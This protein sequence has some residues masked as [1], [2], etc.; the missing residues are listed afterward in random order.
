MSVIDLLY[1]NNNVN[2]L[3]ETIKQFPFITLAGATEVFNSVIK[4]ISSGY[5]EAIHPEL[6]NLY[7]KNYHKA[8][9]GVLGNPQ[10]SSKYFEIAQKFN[11]NMA[12]F[13]AYKSHYATSLLQRLFKDDVKKFKKYSGTILKT[14]NR[15]QATEYNTTVARTRSAKQFIEF[16]A[17]K[18]LY[19]NIEWLATRS[20]TPRELHASFVGLVLPIEHEFWNKNQP[21]NLYNCKCDWQTTD[22]KI[23]D[24]STVTNKVKPAK[25]LEG[26]P[27]RT[28]VLFSNKHSYYDKANRKKIKP[29]IENL[30]YNDEVANFSISVIADETEIAS[31]I[32]TARILK[33]NFPEMDII[34]RPHISGKKNPEYLIDN[35]IADA[36]RIVKYSG[37]KN[38][39]QKAINKQYCKVVIIDFNKHFDT[40]KIIDIDIVVGLIMRRKQD[41][42]NGVKC[43]IVYGDKALE[44]NK[45]NLI[46]HKIK[47]RIKD[48]MPNQ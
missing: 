15:W 1:Y 4:D 27:A 43:Y 16:E 5:T 2:F 37:I 26:N 12:E 11:L 14:F 46:K 36:K 41:F 47:K 38:G 35:Q 10:V 42:I 24:I 32:E 6:F 9:S 31:N 33:N 40:T 39:F 44:I 20:S 25:G 30:F 29:A 28:G 7:Y 21:G 19:P 18:E 34:I 23:N 22:K 48:I 3:Q 17:E 45:Y 13:A 8:I